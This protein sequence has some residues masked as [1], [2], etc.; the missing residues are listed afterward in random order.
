MARLRRLWLRLTHVF[1]PSRG[2]A[3]VAREIA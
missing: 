3:E 2:D 1:R